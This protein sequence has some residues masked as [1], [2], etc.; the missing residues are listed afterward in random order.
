MS[1]FGQRVLDELSNLDCEIIIIDKRKEIIDKLKEKATN[2]FI[3]D[4]INEDTIKKL[5]PSTIDA[6]IIDLGDRIE[7]SILVTNYL[8]K[9]GIREI[10]VKAETDEHGEIL[11]IVGASQ[12]IFPNREAAKRITP[13]LVSD[14]LFNYMPISNG[15][16]IA[17]I[18]VPEKYLGM[19][20]IEADFRKKHGLN[21]VAI[22]EE[23]DGE[24]RFFDPA[25]KLQNNDVFLVVGS[26]ERIA[27]FT[28]NTQSSRRRGIG[29]LF[30]HLFG[31]K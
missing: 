6:A 24:Y 8:K 5:V 1:S 10:I 13:L 16:V 4:A 23:E 25:H 31:R 29:Q 21:V 9:N 27:S 26:E 14:Y 30:K 18:R 3:A 22:K 20:L 11:D 7:V 17:E 15:L 12:V 2:A 19:S 28:G